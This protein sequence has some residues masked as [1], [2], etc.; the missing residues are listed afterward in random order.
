MVA[1][2]VDVVVVATFFERFG[3]FWDGGQFAFEGAFGLGHEY[4]FSVTGD[5]D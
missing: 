4:T 5:C 1:E 2:V 3:F